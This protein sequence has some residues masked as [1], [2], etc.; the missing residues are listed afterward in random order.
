MS[1]LRRFSS[2][3]TSRDFAREFIEDRRIDD[4]ERREHD[5]VLIVL[6]LLAVVASLHS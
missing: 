1:A 6:K 3:Q 5:R 4:E 2:F